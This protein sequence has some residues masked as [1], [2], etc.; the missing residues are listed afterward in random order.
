[1]SCICIYAEGE[2]AQPRPPGAARASASQQYARDSRPRPSTATGPDP[3]S[4][5]SVPSE[6]PHAWSTASSACSD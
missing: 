2:A 3:P 5:W 6:P 1:L 4:G